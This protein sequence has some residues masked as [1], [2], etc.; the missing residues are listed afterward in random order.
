MK[1]NF[2]KLKKGLL[3]GAVF[4]AVSLVAWFGY[5]QW[6]V[7]SLRGQQ[8]H[9]AAGVLKEVGSEQIKILANHI[10]D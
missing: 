10:N 6:G 1:L 9:L 4:V 8:S 7:L 5:N 3:L 2:K